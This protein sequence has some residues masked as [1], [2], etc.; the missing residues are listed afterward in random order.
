MAKQRKINIAEFEK[1]IAENVIGDDSV[2]ELAVNHE[3]SIS[4]RVPIN[5]KDGTESPY[6]EMVEQIK[7]AGSDWRA[8]ALAVIAERPGMSRE[9]QLELWESTG[10]TPGFLLQVWKQQT[11][12]AAERFENFRYRG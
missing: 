3:D 8:A 11:G 2:V 4:I 1:Q 5:I 9:D 6:E 10:R 12:E 7:M